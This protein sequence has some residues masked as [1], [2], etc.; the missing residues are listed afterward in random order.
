MEKS[1]YI[2]QLNILPFLKGCLIDNKWNNI[3]QNLI[4]QV[5][6]K[7]LKICYDSFKNEHL[8]TNIA[9]GFL[10]F[11]IENYRNKNIIYLTTMRFSRYGDRHT[12]YTMSKDLAHQINKRK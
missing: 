2:E 8:S 9:E 10:G 12:I 3:T 5:F 7:Y 11:L 4:N 1:T 6:K